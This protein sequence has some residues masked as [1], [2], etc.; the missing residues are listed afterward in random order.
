MITF[1]ICTI[2]S[3]QHGLSLDWWK[4]GFEEK[5]ITVKSVFYNHPKHEAQVV[6]K[7]K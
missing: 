3:D 1:T 6:L 5:D 2:R 4:T 7:E